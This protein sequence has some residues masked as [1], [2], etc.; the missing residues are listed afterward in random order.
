LGSI[1]VERSEPG[2]AVVALV[3]EHDAYSAPKL[4]L[5]FA[6][7]QFDRYSIVVDLSETTFVDSAIVSVLLRAKENAKD[8]GRKLALVLDETTGDA[9]IRLFDVT[10]LRDVFPTGKTPRAALDAA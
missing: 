2:V 1:V 5:E 10:G 4:E 9:V 8:A 7:L 6:L 3:G